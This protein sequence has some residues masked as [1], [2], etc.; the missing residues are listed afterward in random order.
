MQGT[1]GRSSRGVARRV[2]GRRLGR[3]AAVLAV[4]IAG[5]GTAKHS[6]S[7]AQG[8]RAGGLTWSQPQV[9][10]A[11]ASGVMHQQQVASVS[12]PSVTFCVAVD[13]DGYSETFN[14]TGWGPP[15]KVDVRLGLRS[16]S[17]ASSGF[18]LAGGN[19]DLN[20]PDAPF[21]TYDGSRWS[22]VQNHPSVGTP[23]GD[24]TGML[25]SITCVAAPTCA[26][27]VD[28]STVA[29]FNGRTWSRPFRAIPLSA[30]GVNAVACATRNL[31]VAVGGMYKR[32]GSS[33]AYQYGFATVYDGTRWS[34]PQR[35]DA[36]AGGPPVAISCAP[37][38]F[39][40][41]VDLQGDALTYD[42]GTWS[43]PEKVDHPSSAF[44]VS[45]PTSAF[46]GLT[47]G[48]N[49]LVYDAGSWSNPTV[50]YSKGSLGGDDAI[51]QISCAAV[52]HCV[53]IDSAGSVIV[54]T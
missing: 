15:T 42:Q 6:P 13:G 3:A 14:G 9:I 31:C 38:S 8:V 46:C 11:R 34:A 16:V 45:C 27:L 24:I 26:A 43:Q 17:C 51:N 10:D 32:E 2:P 52:D 41:V 5:C 47:D 49:G 44:S 48:K 1:T 40:V 18:C 4:I 36:A 28:G 20:I 19:Y 22:A 30:G 54:L 35:I 25:T 53:A 12:C 29:T 21:L 37:T 7:S 50:V 23:S 39:C 33:L